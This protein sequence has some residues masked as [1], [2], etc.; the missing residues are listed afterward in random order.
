MSRPRLH[1]RAFAL[2]ALVVAPVY[3]ASARGRGWF[4][5]PRD[6]DHQR[7]ISEEDYLENVR[8]VEKLLNATPAMDPAVPHLLRRRAALAIMRAQALDEG[9]QGVL[10]RCSQGMTVAECDS[11]TAEL[12]SAAAELRRQATALLE[13]AASRFPNDPDRDDT[14]CV[15]VVQ[16]LRLGDVAEAKRRLLELKRSFP[17][18]ERL[19]EL[20]DVL[21]PNWAAALQPK[22]T[23]P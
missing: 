5:Q 15:L 6:S 11:G 14:L 20:T 9:V 22:T 18:S 4:E 1:L 8:L 19:R 7:T 13:D 10:A 16:R 3:G 17:R 12:V 23:K 2:A 21:G